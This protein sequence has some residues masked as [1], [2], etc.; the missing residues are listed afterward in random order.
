MYYNSLMIAAK[1][2]GDKKYDDLIIEISGKTGKSSR[3]KLLNKSNK[4]NSNN[5]SMYN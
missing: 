5:N 4:I 2:L 1:K 3:I